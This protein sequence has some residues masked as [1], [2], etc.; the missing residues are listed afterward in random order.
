MRVKRYWMAIY[1]KPFHEFKVKDALM[2]RG[3]EVFLPT[4]FR[5]IH[6][7]HKKTRLIEVPL[8]RSYV[9]FRTEPASEEFYYVVD[10]PGTVFVLSKNG[11]PLRVED[12]EIESLKILSQSD[13][14]DRLVPHLHLHK[15]NCVVLTEG[16]F[17]GAQ[18][19]IADVDPGKLIFVVNISIL[20]RS[21]SVEVEPSWVKRC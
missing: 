20:G 3:V 21:V 16:P 4:G 11:V 6:N 9:F 18:G 8:F 7:T 5:F 19:I 17:A 15:G 1:T 12:E 14:K 13:L 10:L 2:L